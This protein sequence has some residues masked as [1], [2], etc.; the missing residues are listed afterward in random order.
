MKKINR[1]L[2]RLYKFHQFVLKIA[3]KKW[4]AKI[5]KKQIKEIMF[6]KN[7]ISVYFHVL[8]QNL[9]VKIVYY[10]RFNGQTNKKYRFLLY[11]QKCSK[12]TN[13]LSIFLYNID[14][15]LQN[16]FWSI[17]AQPFFPV[18]DNR[19]V[20]AFGVLKINFTS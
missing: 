6:S 7:R 12:N 3:V 11:L 18:S 8:R 4:W 1:N 20:F 13:F 2:H 19:I 16:K 10:D 15:L 14:L 17:P 9:R 5:W